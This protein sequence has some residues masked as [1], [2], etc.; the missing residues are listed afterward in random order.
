MKQ[1]RTPFTVSAFTDGN[2]ALAHVEARAYFATDEAA[3]AYVAALPKSLRLRVCHIGTSYEANPQFALDR[4]L[5]ALG[6][7]WGLT[8]G[9]SDESFCIPFVSF[10]AD[11]TPN[12]ANKGANETGRRRLARFLSLVEWSYESP[13]VTNAATAEQ[14]TAFVT[15]R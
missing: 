13:Y 6:L 5:N 10:T 4:T 1:P 15:G 7:R 8:T 11:F 14:L 9:V 2:G 12:C 3:T